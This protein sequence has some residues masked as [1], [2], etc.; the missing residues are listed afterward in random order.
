MKFSFLSDIHGNLPA[1]EIALKK[2]GKVDGYII[3]G[4]VVNYGPWSNECVQ[5]IDTL[6]GCT[7]IL[8]NHEEFFLQGRCDCEN[9]LA[10]EFFNH[11]YP[12]FEE[13]ALIQTYVEESQFEDFTC[14][15]TLE[16]KYIFK[17]SVVT[18]GEN[19]II[20]HSHQQY[21]ITRNGFT[22]LNPGSVGQNRQNINE[23]NFMIYDTKLQ[24]A[25]FQSVLYDANIVIKQMEKM[26]YPEVC[27]D[28][29]RNKSF[30]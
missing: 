17:D 11:C 24:K 18:L 14:T 22:L 4:D 23:I 15:H 30:K 5:L 27:L 25:D 29:Y 9:Y 6:P 26:E 3:L 28:Y 1:L 19:Y 2:S 12:K 7:K 10:N 8:G 16:G 20:G 13:I 21:N